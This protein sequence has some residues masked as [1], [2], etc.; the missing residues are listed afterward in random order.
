MA[1]VDEPLVPLEG[2]DFLLNEIRFNQVAQREHF[3]V[4]GLAGCEDFLYSDIKDMA[5]EFGKRTQPKRPHN[6]WSRS[7]RDLLA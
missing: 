7:L 6:L 5:D 2:I 3:M 4:A 1:D